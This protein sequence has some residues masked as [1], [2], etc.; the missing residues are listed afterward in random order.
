VPHRG[1]QESAGPAAG[2]IERAEVVLLQHAQKLREIGRLVALYLPPDEGVDRIPVRS[3]RL[4]ARPPSARP[5][6]RPR[7]APDSSGWWRSDPN[8]AAGSYRRTSI[9][10]RPAKRARTFEQAKKGVRPFSQPHTAPAR[11]QRGTQPAT[12]AA[13]HDRPSRAKGWHR[14]KSAVA[15]AAGGRPTKCR[16]L[17]NGS[18]AERHDGGPTG[19]PGPD[20]TAQ[21][22]GRYA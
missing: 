20:P 18:A 7:R 13:R 8:E 12:A 19:Q 1:A 14:R 3:Q 22:L 21:L 2:R 11:T 15:P 5:S 4:P 6:D 10:V 16:K 17:M 9:S